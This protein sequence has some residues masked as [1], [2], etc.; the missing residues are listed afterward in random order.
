MAK[1]HDV[2]FT[3]IISSDRMQRIFRNAQPITGTLMTLAEEIPRFLVEMQIVH[4][5]HSSDEK[6][7]SRIT[8]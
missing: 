8:C 5:P 1:W 7:C 3:R 2:L 4:R 6:Q